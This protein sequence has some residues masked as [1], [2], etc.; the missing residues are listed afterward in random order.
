VKVKKE[1]QI[2]ISEKS[3]KK[4]LGLIEK[5]YDRADNLYDNFGGVH[6]IYRELGRFSQELKNKA[7]ALNEKKQDLKVRLGEIY[8]RGFNN[9]IYF[10][11]ETVGEFGDM[12]ED[13]I[14]FGHLPR[15]FD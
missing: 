1:K 11:N 9:G 2:I 15:N 7:F 4:I 3:F 12:I 14:F 13:N 10:C 8:K 6:K 5:V